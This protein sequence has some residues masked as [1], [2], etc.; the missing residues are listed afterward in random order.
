MRK[1]LVV[2]AAT[3]LAAACGSDESPS[4]AVDTVGT[5]TT[6]T[7][8]SMTDTDIA[9]LVSQTSMPAYLPVLDDEGR[10]T[11]V[12][13]SPRTIVA[14]V[15]TWCPY[16]EQYVRFLNDPQTKAAL[17]SYTFVFLLER[18]EWPTVERHLWAEAETK[19]LSEAVVKKRLKELKE[20]AGYAPVFSPA[21]LDNLPGKHY[22]L[23]EHSPIAGRAFPGIYDPS[24][25]RCSLHPVKKFSTIMNAADF[26]TLW[27]RYAPAG[28]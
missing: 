16:S 25:S 2:L 6:S 21:F 22:F 26:L 13:L 14:Q 20:D 9:A 27:E 8:A 28:S 12:S 3:V 11:T 23:P 10:P 4:A 24:T 5:D 7:Y 18:D 15:A 1:L 17:Q 19:H